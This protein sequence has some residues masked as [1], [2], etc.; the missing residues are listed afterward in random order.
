MVRKK[1]SKC[2]KTLIIGIHCFA[3]PM[4]YLNCSLW[5]SISPTNFNKI[6]HTTV[7]TFIWL[8]RVFFSKSIIYNTI[9]SDV[10]AEKQKRQ[11]VTKHKIVYSIPKYNFFNIIIVFTL[12][13]M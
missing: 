11:E 3:L 13:Q 9:S 7:I 4:Q 10:R 12:I 8:Y 2:N 5:H 1:V 6:V